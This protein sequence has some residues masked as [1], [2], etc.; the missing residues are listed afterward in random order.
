MELSIIIVNWNAG[1]L[2]NRCIKSIEEETEDLDYEILIF[3]NNSSDGSC[4]EIDK[5]YNNVIL[6]KSQENLGFSKGNN[7]CAKQ[8]AGDYLLFLNPDTIIL[9][10]A[11]QKTFKYINSQKEDTLIGCKLLNDDK[12]IQT[13]SAA[14]LNILNSITTS[15]TRSI[16]MHNMNH[17]TDWVIGAFMMI[18]ADFFKSLGGFDEDYFMYAEDMDLCYKVKKAG[19]KVIYYSEAQIIHF[20]NQS[21]VKKWKNKRQLKILQSEYLFMNKRYSKPKAMAIKV[22]K[23]I[24]YFIKYLIK[25]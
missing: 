25:K 15:H 2:L 21:G 17:E 24:R 23:E 6:I 8:A 18:K 3:D 19:G 9:E 1:D 16:K 5:K 7:E 22:I 20:F 10:G 13:S 11:V 4:A 12:T 14:Y